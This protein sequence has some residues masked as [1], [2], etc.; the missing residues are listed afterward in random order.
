MFRDVTQ[1][2]AQ[3][4]LFS[5]LAIATVIVVSAVTRSCAEQ[6]RRNEREKNAAD[7]SIS[8]RVARS[9]TELK[10]KPIF[11]DHKLVRLEYLDGRHS[12]LISCTIDRCTDE[13][14]NLLNIDDGVPS[15]TPPRQ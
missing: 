5:V 4:I 6:E 1:K 3:R 12:N 11:K 13:E 9:G 8:V 15:E 7:Y 14:G 2:N 10:A